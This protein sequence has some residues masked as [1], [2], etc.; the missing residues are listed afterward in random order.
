MEPYSVAVLWLVVIGFIIAFILAFGIGA[1]D[2][3]NSF[4]T[5]VGSGVLTIRQ[6]CW[7]A[8]IC[9]VSGAV[10]IG[11]K[12]SDTMRK[13]ILE[14][15]DYQGHEKEL[16]LGLISALGSSA[17]W[18]LAATF[19]KLPISGT[20]SI[21]G[22]T[23]GF[24][25]VA[26]G[27]QGLN[28]GKLGTIVGSWFVSP[29]MSGLMSV[30]LY[31]GINKFILQ[32]KNPLKSGLLSLPL[33]Y[34]ITLF[35]NVFSIVHEGP[36]L[37][38][39]DNIPTWVGLLV[40]A[41]IGIA[42]AIL[43]Q[44]I[45]V[46]WQ[47]R[48]ILGQNS[49]GKPVNFTFGDSDDSS[50]NSSPKRTKRPLSLVCEYNQLPAI[51]EST[52]LQSLNNQSITTP[53]PQNGNLDLFR[54]PQWNG[55]TNVPSLDNGKSYKIDPE[56]VKKAEELLGG[57]NQ[58]KTTSLDNTDL[59]ITSLN[60]IDEYQN[61]VNGRNLQNLYIKSPDLE[62]NDLT[63]PPNIIL[64]NGT[65]D[66][67]TSTVNNKITT[68]TAKNCMDNAESGISLDGMLLNNNNV[69]TNMSTNSSKAPLISQSAT[70]AQI[71]AEENDENVDK[72]FSF[73][74]ILTATFGSFAHGGNDV[75]NAIGPLIALWLI[76]TEGSVMQQSETPLWI[77]LFGGAGISV[78]LWLWGRRV[79]ETVGTDLT[80]I[81]PA[82]GFTIE[83]GAAMTVLLAS[84]IGIP[85]STT[86][87][88]VGSV[89]FVGYT[90]SKKSAVNGKQ[91]QKAV[92][93]GLFRN[94]VYAWV[95]TV[96]VAALLSA[97]F[98]FILTR[99]LL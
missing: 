5:S 76:Y 8:T 16:M 22:S 13:G 40:S 21:V 30:G 55:K 25:L 60:Y 45:I 57:N 58:L 34:G 61:T 91:Q 87:C 48:K 96:P 86:H 52:E 62:A 28:W 3:A 78:G 44:L 7:L 98:M 64:N 49:N 85:I 19:L 68:T 72:L 83:I 9:E 38:K 15:S 12:V 46:P 66:L 14:V 92:D 84:K 33:F 29:V 56:I 6:A 36:K 47:R 41:G 20:H 63:L 18:L 69:N 70:A 89:V 65:N 53:Q 27:T 50:A 74:Q 90:N 82:T 23:I 35:V 73:L 79:I 2:V 32:T 59:T 88:K 10:L 26:R 31:M 42:V 97:A 77:L 51:T 80:K 39:M 54:V 75:S 94:I 17:L 67:I 99:T 93:W 11:Y 4:G 37:L 24:S 81:T 43:V 71:K 1:N 95:V